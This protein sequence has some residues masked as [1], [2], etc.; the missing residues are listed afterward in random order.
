MTVEISE[1]LVQVTKLV[2][3]LEFIMKNLLCLR[4]FSVRY[5]QQ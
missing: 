2:N 3:Q 5:K 4:L 1:T